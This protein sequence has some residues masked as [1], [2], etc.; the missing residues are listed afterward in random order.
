MLARRGG[1]QGGAPGPQCP[2]VQRIS[3]RRWERLTSKKVIDAD[4][5]DV[6]G[7]GDL[8][9]NMVMMLMILTMMVMVLRMMK[10]RKPHLVP[11]V[12]TL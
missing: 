7:G 6:D 3:G 12:P 9:G 8:N 10:D 5:L 1:R 4:D 11:S 2:H